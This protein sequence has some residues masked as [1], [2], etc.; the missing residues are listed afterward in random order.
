[1]ISNPSR[2]CRHRAPAEHGPAVKGKTF[3]PETATG[4]SV[5]AAAA[6]TVNAVRA[7]GRSLTD[8]IVMFDEGLD[9]R[10]LPLLREL[11]TGTLRLLPRLE[12]LVA[13]LLRRPMK[14]ADKDLEALL[15]V[16]LYQ[17]EALRVPAHAAVAA[18][19]DATRAL[20]KPWAAG[21]VNGVLRRWLREAD[22]LEPRLDEDPTARWL[23]PRWLLDRLV[24]A[25]PEHW[26][27]IAAAL[28]GRAP[29]QLRVNRTRVDRDS[30]RRRLAAEGVAASALDWNDVGLL[31]DAAVPTSRLPGFDTGLVSVQDAGAQLAADLLDVH[32]GDSVLDC[33]AAP[34]GK[35]AHLLERSSTGGSTVRLTAIDHDKA[36]LDVLRATLDRLGLEAEVVAGDTAAPAGAWAERHYQR[37]LLDAPCSATGVIRRH[38][39]IKCLRRDADIPR[40]ASIQQRMLD[41]VWPLLA[42]G[43]KLLYATCSILPDENEARIDRFLSEHA[44]AREL[45]IDADWGL[46]RRHGRQLL[47]ADGGADGFYYALL[48]KTVG[49]GG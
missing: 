5:R 19:V 47:P 26:Q 43:G 36:R 31:L 35:S 38:P 29:M 12:V 11:C 32:A 33:C 44:D 20:H 4:A 7:Q 17:L 25:W 41:A 28:M 18:T 15:M 30:Y 22:T 16:G 42:P 34:G 3:G 40:L 49:T 24:A 1:V 2:R 23:L 8:A 45:A 39:D 37:I 13:R 9:R 10:D 14:A 6:R 27:S 21:L 46:A 48:V